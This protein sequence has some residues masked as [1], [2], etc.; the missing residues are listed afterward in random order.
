MSKLL[1][2]LSLIASC[3]SGYAATLITEPEITIV[4]FGP[5]KPEP[6]G[7]P[8]SL[9][10]LAIPF[11]PE[12]V[13]KCDLIVF[14]RVFLHRFDR[15]NFEAI[16]TTLPRMDE[17]V[18]ES[19][20]A[21]QKLFRKTPDIEKLI[22]TARRLHLEKKPIPAEMTLPSNAPIPR[23]SDELDMLQIVSTR[24]ATAIYF[25]G[26]E[27]TQPMKVDGKTQITRVPSLQGFRSAYTDAA[28]VKPSTPNPAR[29]VV[30]LEQRVPPIAISPDCV[31]QDLNWQSGSQKCG[32]RYNSGKNGSVVRI[33]NTTVQL[34][35][36]IFASCAS[37]ELQLKEAKCSSADS[38]PGLRR[39]STTSS[40]PSASAIAPVPVPLPVPVAGLKFK[41]CDAQSI[42]WTQES[43]ACSA[44]YPVG[45]H[46]SRLTLLDSIPPAV[47]T[48]N[49]ICENGTVKVT[50][51]ACG[52]ATSTG[53]GAQVF[54][55]TQGDSACS[56]DY[57]GGNT[58]SSVHVYDSV[59]PVT[60]SAMATCT[61]GQLIASAQL[62][63]TAIRVEM[64]ARDECSK[65]DRSLIGQN[66]CEQRL[67]ERD[68]NF[69]DTKYCKVLREKSSAPIRN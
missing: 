21:S 5:V 37:G 38:A 43:F 19:Q 26:S 35:G 52:L 4:I 27:K 23:L 61:N 66:L 18:R 46:G 33:V 10:D 34:M 40:S 12:N 51:S 30:L 7:L 50:S 1:L 39:T 14:P 59:G 31:A 13:K 45:L 47:G 22:E 68:P 69:I 9:R 28:C 41:D 36:S 8:K 63:K 29:K 65:K 20:N 32:G 16:E 58:G 15:G 24:G 55:W 6:E 44:M 17:I 42:S 49:A 3:A 62:C 60:G 56:A 57:A 54:N 2:T 11:A 67:C 25:I 64:S 48:A 53:C